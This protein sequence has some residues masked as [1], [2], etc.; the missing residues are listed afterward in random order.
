MQHIV[1]H[2][3]RGMIDD[4]RGQWSIRRLIGHAPIDLI[5]ERLR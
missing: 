5:A 2:H 1:F 3:L 4:N